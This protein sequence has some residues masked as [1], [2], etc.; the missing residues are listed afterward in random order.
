MCEWLSECERVQRLVCVGVLTIR[1]GSW[2]P[3]GFQAC[4]N[5]KFPHCPAAHSRLQNITKNKH[6][7]E[8]PTSSWPVSQTPNSIWSRPLLAEPTAGAPCRRIT[9]QTQ[10]IRLFM[11]PKECGS[12]P[13][14]VL[15]WVCFTGRVIRRGN[16]QLFTEILTQSR[17]RRADRRKISRFS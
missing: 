8:N 4:R 5:T 9:G 7:L 11:R 3:S 15:L 12:E 10:L 1:A 17:K 13:S 16:D 2:I 14:G 6:K